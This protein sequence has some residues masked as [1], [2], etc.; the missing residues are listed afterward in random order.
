M[1][2]TLVTPNPRK[3]ASSYGTFFKHRHNRHCSRLAV[4]ALA[5]AVPA[6]RLNDNTICGS[7]LASRTTHRTQPVQR[8]IQMARPPTSL[9]PTDI[10]DFCRYGYY[11]GLKRFGRSPEGRR[12]DFLLAQEHALSTSYAYSYKWARFVTY[13][14]TSRCQL[15]ASVETVG[16]YLGYLFRKG[17]V[18]ST[19]IW[20]YLAAIRAMH[21]RTEFQSPTE[22]H[23]IKALPTGYK[24][25]TSDRVAF[26]PSSLALPVLCAAKDKTSVDIMRRMFCCNFLRISRL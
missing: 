3:R 20:P 15:P 4:S 6:C 10:T 8:R 21:T 1:G 2:L 5:P 22:E 7:R 24:R 23:V 9:P 16:C 17:R 11:V 14:G 13:C 18:T 25:A 19:S 26:R 12:A